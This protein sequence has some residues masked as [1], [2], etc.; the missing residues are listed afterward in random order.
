M[1][2]FNREQ[3][4]VDLAIDSCYDYLKKMFD[5]SISNLNARCTAVTTRLVNYI[6]EFS[7]AITKFEGVEK[8][9]DE[10][11]AGRMSVSFIKTQKP[12]YVESLRN[13][14]TS[15]NSEI[16]AIRYDTRY[17]ELRAFQLLF[18]DFVSRVL[19][20]NSNF[21]GVVMG[22]SDEMKFFKKPFSNIEKALKDLEYELARGEQG[23]R[24]YTALKDEINNV[25]R[26]GNELHSIIGVGNIE[27]SEKPSGLDH[28][29]AKIKGEIAETES[30]I[31]EY[32]RKLHSIAAEIEIVL[33]PLERPA[34]KY[35]HLDTKKHRLSQQLGAP[36]KE[37]S[38]EISYSGFMAAL[39]DMRSKI[40]DKTI[41]VDNDAQILEQI[42]DAIDSGID[43]AIAEAGSI[44]EQKKEAVQR[45]AEYKNELYGL[46]KRASSI[47]SEARTKRQRAERE[48]ELRASLESSKKAIEKMFMD[49]FNSKVHVT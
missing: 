4:Q 16:A 32:D 3:K 25:I 22:Y 47:E 27:D 37:L 45:M 11:F 23:F 28:E 2:F 34:R 46:Q 6:E 9:P 20:I 15:L 17:E 8:D 30:R 31:N 1:S 12:K 44:E 42:D 19:S 43:S 5:S 41:S 38:N 10:E 26:L 14:V 40:A 49:Y 48:A 33:K 21:R 24:S 36:L 39:K 35:D 29:I 7:T 18:A 13:A